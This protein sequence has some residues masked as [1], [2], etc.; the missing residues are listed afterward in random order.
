[1]K[2]IYIDIRN[3]EISELFPD[4]DLVSLDDLIEVMR[5]LYI[6]NLN[7]KET[8]EDLKEFKNQVV[9]NTDPYIELGLTEEDFC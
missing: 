9:D 5:G 2:D 4:Q 7:N 3:M 8:I 1:M 6:D